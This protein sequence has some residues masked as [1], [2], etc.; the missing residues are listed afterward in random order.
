MNKFN[1]NFLQVLYPFYPIWAWFCLQF[2]HLPVEKVLIFLLLPSVFYV[3]WT[4]HIRFPAYLTIFSLFTVFHLWTVFYNDLLP[5]NTNWFFYIFSDF[6]V[7]TCALLFVVENTNFDDEFIE[8]MNKMV[9]VVIGLSLLVSIVQIKNPLFF[10]YTEAGTDVIDS[11]YFEESRNASIY[12]WVSQNSVGI[13]FPFL[14]C[15]MVSVYQIRSKEFPF[16]M[17]SGVIVA[18]LTRARYVMI[19]TVIAFSQLF[20]GN[21]LRTKTKFA[22]I[23]AFVAGLGLIVGAA[24]MSGFKIQEVINERIL[25]KGT[26]MKSAKARIL[27]YEVFLKKFPEHPYIGVGPKTRDDVVDLLE[28]EAPLIHV[29]Y[30]SYLYYYGVLGASLLFI[31]LLLLLYDSWKV[32]RLYGF[33]GAFYGFIGFLL[34]NATFVYFHLN[35]MGIVL[36]LLYMRYYKLRYERLYELESEN[37]DN[38]MEGF[39]EKNTNPLN[40]V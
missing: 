12:S 40:F 19:S 11:V 18:F 9:L 36:G 39:T 13:T 1:Q 32:G 4:M 23:I 20:I 26:D 38:N 28:G 17:I 8:R 31:C 34:A 6:N 3:I 35:E 10:V 25:E 7:L 14:L 37:S 16:I 29:G 5:V 21:R 22:L 15:I 33:W 24:Q 30:L 27:S 2:L